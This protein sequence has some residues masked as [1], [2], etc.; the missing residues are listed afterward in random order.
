[1]INLLPGISST[2]SALR[3]EQTRME[4]IA[5]N[6]ANANTTHDVDGQPYR[7]QQVVFEAVLNQEQRAGLTGVG[8]HEVQVARIEKDPR[9]PRT[10]FNPS[11]VDAD[12]NGMV[13]AP[14]VSIHEEMAD[15]IASSRAYEANLAVARNSHALAMQALSIG[16]R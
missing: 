14:N 11:S 2:T 6:I 12:A 1:M 8:S 10:F 13:Q 4:V 3:A 5:Q 16:K 15:L 7:R 9:P